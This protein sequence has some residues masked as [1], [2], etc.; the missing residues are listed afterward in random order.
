[1]RKK[2]RGRHRSQTQ[3]STLVHP[4]TLY[5]HILFYFILFFTKRYRERVRCK[6][7]Q[8]FLWIIANRESVFSRRGEIFA[9]FLL[10]KNRNLAKFSPSFHHARP[11]MYLLYYNDDAYIFRVTKYK[12]TYIYSYINI[13]KHTQ[14]L[15]RT[16]R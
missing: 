4:A 8:D 2:Q 13:Y 16:H 12:F 14:F 7:S 5:I 15:S 11:R 3:S 9:R 10:L 6:S 1:M